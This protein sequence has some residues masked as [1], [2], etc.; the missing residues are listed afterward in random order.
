MKND[1]SIDRQKK[2]IRKEQIAARHT[3]SPE[4][5]VKTNQI[6][7]DKLF[8]RPE[9]KKSHVICIYISLPDE[10][11]TKLL[12]NVLLKQGKTV[13]VPKVS[14][15]DDKVVLHVIKS[16][17]DLAP[18]A[19][20]IL[21]PIDGSPVI[22]VDAVDLFI[23]PGVAFDRLGHRL[24]WGKGHYDRLLAGVMV[25]K[26]GLAYAIQ[27]IAQVPRSSYDISMDRIITEKATFVCRPGRSAGSTNK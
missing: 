21:E 9:W 27:V 24:G 15:A 12:V 26:I 16:M 6:I 20:Q 8:A 13:V 19:L 18:G 14:S 4:Q 11:D 23:V 1:T 17:D 2:V 3:I 5:K 7:A 22:L 25:P 10:V